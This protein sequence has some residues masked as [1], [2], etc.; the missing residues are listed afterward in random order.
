MNN[1]NDLI[2]LL[3]LY[4]DKPWDWDG[5][6]SN[7]NITWEFVQ[8]NPNKPWEW[9]YLHFNSNIMGNCSI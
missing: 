5:L 6:S 9:V 1:E 4:P 7:P 8:A 2:K 3:D